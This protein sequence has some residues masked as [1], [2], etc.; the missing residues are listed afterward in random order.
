MMG[1]VRRACM[2]ISSLLVVGGCA[3]DQAASQK[4]SPSRSPQ[5]IQQILSQ[6]KVIP[7]QI[8]KNILMLYAPEPLE[9]ARA[10]YEL[11][12]VGRGAAPAIP[13]LVELLG[14]QS[15][16]LFSRYLGGGYHSSFDTTPADE[17]S[18]ALA[19]IGEDANLALVEVTQS[20]QAN[21]RRLAATAL[22]QIGGLASIPRLV[23][24]LDDRDET[25]RSAAANAL[26]NYRHPRAA[27]MLMD[28][29]RVASASAR[30][31]MIY[32]LAQIND[33]TT[34]PFLIERLPSEEPKVHAAILYALGELRDAR[35]LDVLLKSLAHK[36]ATIRATGAQALANYYSQDV[37]EAL[38][39]LLDDPAQQVREAVVE[40]LFTLTGKN[41]GPNKEKWH[42]WWQQQKQAIQG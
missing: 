17:A 1:S 34:V 7:V 24:L 28:A 5:E 32:A 14:D 36:D 37:I 20:K 41:Y 10:A 3:I 23:E 40:A 21:K 2:A 39:V 42:Q 4:Y 15:P 22:G 8:R 35:A 25:V 31:D 18:N 9:R 13:Y 16:V 11:G 19:N 33:I 30:A 38:L 6:G 29:I 12:K 26:G 27:Q